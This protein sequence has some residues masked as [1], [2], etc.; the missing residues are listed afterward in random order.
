MHWLA[1]P[2]ATVFYVFCHRKP[3]LKKSEAEP[4]VCSLLGANSYVFW[5]VHCA[6]QQKN[7]R[8]LSSWLGSDN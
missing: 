7:H 5:L 8:K 1:T 2:G 4:S 6:C 3:S